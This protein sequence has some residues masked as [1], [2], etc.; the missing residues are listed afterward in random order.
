MEKELGK[1][2]SLASIAEEMNSSPFY[3]SRIFRE[4]RGTSF[5]E[6]LKSL[7]MEKAHYLLHDNALKAKE[8]SRMVGYW[9]PNYFIKVFKSYYGIIPGEFRKTV[10][11]PELHKE[12]G[13]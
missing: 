1:N 5:T 13:L 11:S 6:H 8:V 7:R 2:I 9:S 12:T 4:V 10:N 3:L